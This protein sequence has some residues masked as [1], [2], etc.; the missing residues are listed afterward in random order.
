MFVNT[1]RID[2]TRVIDVLGR[3]L[4][5]NYLGNFKDFDNDILREQTLLKFLKDKQGCTDA[6]A[7]EAVKRLRRTALCSDKETLRQANQK[8]KEA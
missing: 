1:E 8:G 4:H 2:Q 5:Y 3:E 6:Q 7:Q